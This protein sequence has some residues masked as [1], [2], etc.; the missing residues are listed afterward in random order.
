VMATVTFEV[1]AGGDQA[2]RIA[3]IV[4]RDAANHV[5]NLAV[6]V[7]P[8]DV[9]AVTSLEFAG[10]NPFRDGTALS[11]ALAQAGPVEVAIYS[12][13]GRRVR[14]LLSGVQEPGTYRLPWNGRDDDGRSVA[15]GVYYVRLAAASRSFTRRVIC[16]R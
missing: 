10:P 3:S 7:P 4:A 15:S 16:L 1:I 14:T 6:A 12:V 13:D 9:P 8:R 11:L 2:I 5:V